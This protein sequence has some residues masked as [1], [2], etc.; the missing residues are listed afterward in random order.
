MSFVVALLLFMIAMWLLFA[1]IVPLRLRLRRKIATW[2]ERRSIGGDV[3]SRTAGEPGS[4]LTI[5]RRLT[6]TEQRMRS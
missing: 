5:R 4:Q 3:A 2:M 1:V 6:Q